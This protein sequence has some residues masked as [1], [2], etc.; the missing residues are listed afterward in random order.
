[1]RDELPNLLVIGAQKCGTTSLHAY[2]GAHP[3]I[4]MA[5]G[6]E[7]DFFIRTEES[8]PTMVGNWDRGLEWYRSRF[9]G[10]GERV[11]GES[12]PNY[13]VHPFVRGVPERAA[14]VVPDAKL[15][16]LVRDPIE[17]LVSHYVHQVAAGR[18]RR[19]IDEA[20]ADVGSTQS[21][22]YLF[23]SMYSMQVRRWLEAYP[24]EALLIASQEELLHD[25]RST[26][27]RI[28]SF[29]G[30]DSAVTAPDFERLSERSSEKRSSGAVE[31]RLRHGSIR[32]IAERVPGALRTPVGKAAR[33]V[34]GRRIARPG[35][36][37]ETRE[38]LRLAFAAD[39]ADLRQLTGR[40]FSEWSV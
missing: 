22:G 1:M 5:A 40:T 16:Y 34:A 27:N 20:V 21:S 33:A 35:M 23:R 24:E 28:F 11:R 7:L 8:I 3:E 25:R 12:S 14:S 17:R 26:L 39:V 38:A 36:K 19:P 10:A 6:K 2:L 32:R 30:V 18:E 31:R 15:V 4:F 29:L 9:R 37:S 13:T